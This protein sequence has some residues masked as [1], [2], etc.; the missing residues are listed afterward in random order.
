[1]MVARGGAQ[2]LR[3]FRLGPGL[4]RGGRKE[5][6]AKP[7]SPPLVPR[8]PADPDQFEQELRQAHAFLACGDEH[9]LG[10]IGVAAAMAAAGLASVLNGS[11]AQVLHAA[12]RALEPHLRAG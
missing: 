6:C 7:P 10:E 11:N 2:L 8:A 9:P 5:N 4:R 3:P 1:M 12:E